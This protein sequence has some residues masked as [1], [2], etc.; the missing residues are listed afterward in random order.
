MLS[1]N[2]E[3]EIRPPAAQALA[4]LGRRADGYL[5]RDTPETA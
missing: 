3:R 4:R 2:F 1:F 5:L